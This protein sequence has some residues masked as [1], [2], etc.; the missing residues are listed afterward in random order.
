MRE[1]E[2]PRVRPALRIDR[3]SFL[4][5]AGIGA[6]AAAVPPIRGASRT[7]G[8]PNIVYIM[9]DELGYYELSCMGHPHFRT[10]NIDRLAAE[11]VRFTQ[12]L[13][14]APVCAPTRC[15]FLTGKHAGHTSVRINP[16]GTPM[17]AEEETIAS[18]LKRRGYATGGFGKWGCGGRGSSGA[19]EKHGFDVFFGYYDQV[20]AHTYYPPYLI[21]NSEE[22][23]LPGNNGGRKGK[24]YSH[25]VIME[26][27]KK[28]IRDNRS[29]P[30]FCYLPI[31]PPHGMFDIPENDPAWRL[32]ADKDWPHDV[33]AYAAMVNMVDR[34]VGEI[35]GLLRDLGLEENT[36]VFFSGDNGGFDY[37]RDKNHPRGFHAPNVNPRT[38]V[39]FR[40]HKG[41]LYEG[42][43]RIPMI[44]YWKGKIRGG[45]VSDFLWY[46][47]DVL[48][49]LAELSGA[50]V[51]DG[52][53]GLS[54]APELLGADA[55]G[56][57]QQE[58]DFL[59]WEYAGQTAVRQGAWKAVRPKPTAPWELYDLAHDIEEKRNLA[60]QR[61]EIVRRLA[62]VA[63]REHEPA[64]PGVF[65][66]MR[67]ENKDRLAKWGKTPENIF[68]EKGLIPRSQYKIVRVSTES[69]FNGRTAACVLDGD[70][71]SHWHTKFKGAVA[72]PPHEL[73]I[74]LGGLHLVRGIRYLARQ[75]GSWN[76]AFKDVEVYV[77]ND[78]Q[79]FDQPAAR[80]TLKK[81]KSVQE[82]RFAPVRGRYVCIRVLSEVNGNPWASAAEIGVI[83]D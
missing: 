64:R 5:A 49:T 60:A 20:H 63:E 72:R 3:R 73:V 58:H 55:A 82:V 70:P 44:V 79:H 48:P 81:T 65:Y 33:K 78:P 28:F 24:T 7:N 69:T 80:A 67:L 11:G 59:Y 10:P 52:V 32:Y 14:G 17:R 21:R 74:D 45:R 43:L 68:P 76:G 61:P 27:A 1:N 13:A 51:P 9:S 2:E 47:P 30:F 75:D 16:G 6:A 50:P 15:C 37:F 62:A 77:S 57:A 35:L 46:F 4:R 40:G 31:T 71:L 25:Y 23:P 34:N 41:N 18:V 66:T 12:A 36:I 54:L 22:V 83:G 42:G 26:E 53:D 8:P 19:P 38:G 29:R 56:R 39:A